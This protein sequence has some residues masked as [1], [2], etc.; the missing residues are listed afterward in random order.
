MSLTFQWQPGYVIDGAQI[1]EEHKRL[2]DLANRVF[3]FTDPSNQVDEVTETVKELFKYMKL[4]FANE[5][6]LM[7]EVGYPD[8]KQHAQ[9]HGALVRAMNGLLRNGGDL[10]N[11]LV[12]L[13]HA[14][15]DWVVWHIIN[16]D[17]KIAEYVTAN[18]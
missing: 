11:L 6:K 14:M 16:E 4:H 10:D 7:Q 13:R 5:Q 2:L 18:A 1:D 17:K 8:Y 9:A 3:D 12:N 15:V